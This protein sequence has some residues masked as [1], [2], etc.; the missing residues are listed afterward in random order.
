MKYQYET[1]MILKKGGS[2]ERYSLVNNLEIDGD[3]ITFDTTCDIRDMF[4][5]SI[6]HTR[7]VEVTGEVI[8]KCTRWEGDI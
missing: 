7:H 4:K 2:Q 1:I 6:P 3:N 5:D 8:E